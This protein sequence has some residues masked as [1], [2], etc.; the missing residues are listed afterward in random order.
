MTKQT[1]ESHGFSESKQYGMVYS[2]KYMPT[3]I[4]RV[5]FPYLI[6]PNEYQGKKSWSITLCFPKSGAN[7]TALMAIEQVVKQMKLVKYGDPNFVMDVD[8]VRD[9]DLE[10]YEGY[11]GN[12][13]IR[14]N[15]KYENFLQGVP[16][17][18]PDAKKN[19][20]PAQIISGV[21]CIILVKP[22]LSGV[23]PHVQ[24]K[25]KAAQCVSYDLEC[26]QYVRDDGTRYKAGPDVRSFLTAL[27]GVEELVEEDS[28]PE[29][30][31][32][33]MF[34]ASI[35]EVP[36]AIE[37]QMI[38]TAPETVTLNVPAAKAASVMKPA[39]AAPTMPRPQGPKPVGP[40]SRTKMNINNA[41]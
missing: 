24:G 17:V 22:K 21:E 33:S 26:V 2:N 8:F 12:W 30:L 19:M 11:A 31:G 34:T 38:P 5:Q 40:V 14:A 18:G 28:P 37:K 3:P 27:T 1:A 23:Y 35:D 39:V 10:K 15:A 20:D 4:G 29:S 13:Y 41:L 32:A 16:V 7:L 9:G 6:K 36:P 25:P